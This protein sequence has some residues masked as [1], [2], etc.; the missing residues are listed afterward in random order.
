MLCLYVQAPFAAF[1]TFTAGSFRPT[2]SF[3]T[4]SGAY[5]LLL[6]VAGVE[7]RAPDDGK[8]PMTQIRQDL[9]AVKIALGALSFPGQHTIFQQ[10]HNY[11]VGASGSERAPNT[12]G[13]K[14][15]IVPARRAFLSNLRA[16]ICIR[17][18]EALEE[19][20]R[21]G[22][23][24]KHQRY[25][26]PFFGDSNYLLDKLESVD[27]DRIKP[28]YW[29]VRM[30]HDAESEYTEGVARLTITIDRANMSRTVSMLFRP[31]AEVTS[32][33]PDSAWVEVNYG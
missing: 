31:L 16:Y 2:A 18:D 11:P 1:R 4:P 12:K 30:E 13:N 19:R 17:G 26:I 21:D 29:Y 25:G 14:Y 8:S 27:I 7:M 9:P 5:G 15:N 6:N 28:A 32:A 33:I 10:L 22:L 24:G 23:A 20:I 3:I